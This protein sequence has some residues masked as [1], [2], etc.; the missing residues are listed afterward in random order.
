MKNSLFRKYFSI[1][2]LC[3]VLSITVLGAVLM[4]FASQYF[5]GEQYQILERNAGHAAYVTSASYESNAIG[6]VEPDAIAD[7]YSI[8]S[9]AVGA[10]FLLTDTAGRVIYSSTMGSSVEGQIPEAAVREA[11]LGHFAD[12]G[13]LG[14]FFSDVHYV[15]GVPVMGFGEPVGTVFA[16]ASA[17]S[18]SAFRVDL[19]RMFLISAAVVLFIAFVLIYFITSNLVRPLRE[20]LLAT[21]SFSQGDFTKRVQVSGFDELGQLAMAFNNMASSLA[22]TETT[23]RTFVAN[24][25]HELKT[26]MTTIGGFVDGILDGTIPREKQDQYMHVVSNEVRRLSRLVHS[27]LDTARIETGEFRLVCVLFDISEIIRQTVLTFEQNIEE[28]QLN[29]KGL[30]ADKIMVWADRDLMHQVVYNLV[31]N[32][33]KFV[34]EGGELSVRYQT[35]AQRTYVA[36]RNT[37]E[38]IDKSEA[39][40]LF[41]R[42]Y[43]S[44]RS[45]SL[46]KNGVG[47]GLHIV[48]SIINYHK[49]EIFVRSEQGEY[50]EFEFCLPNP[51]KNVLKEMEKESREKDRKEKNREPEHAS[52]PFETEVPLNPEEQIDNSEA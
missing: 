7:Y 11:L 23:R 13:L 37:G 9:L 35:D 49:G 4:V 46:N 15:V 6:V 45:R 48:K 30:E 42:F 39:P 20:M 41:E 52:N 31:E 18:L 51:P 40:R 5:R 8:F 43:K 24:V 12:T 25:S 44:D 16:S 22:A 38:G 19:M 36:I 28:K 27:M 50:A 17:E 1:F 2:S 32:A 29:L 47:L 34:N 26:P 10:E 33:V 14:G 21:Q 3:I